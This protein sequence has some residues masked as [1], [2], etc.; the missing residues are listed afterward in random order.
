MQIP[1][2]GKKPKA[3]HLPKLSATHH[4]ADL[5]AL[6]QYSCCVLQL[7]CLVHF[8]ANRLKM[9]MKLHG[10]RLN[11]PSI[12]PTPNQEAD[13]KMNHNLEPLS[14]DDCLFGSI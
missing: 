1:Q 14:S 6:M 11:Q 7:I 10:A 2:Q 4:P 8:V 5:E 13:P 3:N 9:D 12:P